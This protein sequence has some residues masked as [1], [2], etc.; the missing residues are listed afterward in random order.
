MI[1]SQLLA[2][3]Q[4]TNKGEGFSIRPQIQYYHLR[5]VQFCEFDN[6][7]HMQSIDDSTRPKARLLNTM[8]WSVIV[9]VLAIYG[10]AAIFIRLHY[11]KL[12]RA[13]RWR[14]T[15]QG[16]L[17][18]PVVGRRRNPSP[19][20]SSVAFDY[21]R[22]FAPTSLASQSSSSDASTQRTPSTLE[23]QVAEPVRRSA[24]S[25]LAHAPRP[26]WVTIGSV[27]EGLIARRRQASLPR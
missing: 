9:F 12:F 8:Q 5:Y 4:V 21:I 27:E 18:P 25:R 26:G 24:L 17:E 11:L 14:T 7:H 10:C 23:S 22:I 20:P 6:L 16:G 1:T 2:T 19:Y 3:M 15:S 13:Q